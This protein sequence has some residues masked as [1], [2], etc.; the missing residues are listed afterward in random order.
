MLRLG[1]SPERRISLD[2]PYKV[3]IHSSNNKEAE[4]AR[5]GPLHCLVRPGEFVMRMMRTVGLQ[6]LLFI[7]NESFHI[8]L[9]V[10][11]GCRST[12]E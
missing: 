11:Q 5:P 4:S 6:A 10:F 7:I 2:I 9:D 12:F 3:C 1:K 8:V